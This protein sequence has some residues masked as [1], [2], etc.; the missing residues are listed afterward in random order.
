MKN[1][2]KRKKAT[3]EEQEPNE[4]NMNVFYQLNVNENTNVTFSP[5]KEDYD[6]QNYKAIED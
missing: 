6:D 2:K 1:P 4:K 3:E 5:H